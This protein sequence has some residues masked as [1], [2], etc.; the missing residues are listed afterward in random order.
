MS[1]IRKLFVTGVLCALV[2][3]TPAWSVTEIS[4]PTP[5]YLA[6]TTLLP[7]TV[8][9]GTLVGSLSDAQLTMTISPVLEA[10]TVPAGGW[11]T[12]N[13]PPAVETSTPRV[14]HAVN[15]NDLV[16][17]VSL[18]F[19]SQLSTFGFEAEPDPFEVHNITASYYSGALLLDSITRSVQG[20]AGALLF[21]G[22]SDVAFDRVVVT[23]DID[24]A[25]AQFRYALSSSSPVP[26]PATWAF[27]IIGFGAIGA[28]M[29]SANRKA[30]SPA[31][32]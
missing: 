29:R 25:M 9:D 18:S 19:S 31:T 8:A 3:T 17:S 22:T 5:A 15:Y 30:A 11:S 10:G 28:A 14:L 24:F 16:T 20:Q 1:G 32:T 7:I 4:T 21:A 23:S 2:P 12:W 13:F 26:E 27:M 6:S